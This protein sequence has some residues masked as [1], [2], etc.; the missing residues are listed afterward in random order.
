[1]KKEDVTSFI[2][3]ILMIL[4]ALLLGFTFISNMFKEYNST[5][6]SS[7]LNPYVFAI[8]SIVLAVLVNAIGLEVGH[9]IGGKI[10]GY[11]I[12]SVNILGFCFYKAAGKFKFKF[13]DFDGL[14]GETILA[15]KSEKAN[16]KPYVWFPLLFYFVELIVCIIFNSLGQNSSITLHHNAFVWLGTAAM[17]FITIA[18]MMALYNFVPF[19][20]DSMTDGYRLTLMSKKVNVEA[21]NELMRIE[22]LQR[23]GKEIDKI[24]YF[25]E[26]TEFTA[27]INLMTIYEYLSKKEFEP[28]LALIEKMAE[29]K[30]KLTQATIYRLVAQKLYIKIMTLPIEEAQKYYEEEVDDSIRRFISNDLSMESLRAYILIAGMLD[31]SNAEVT[32]ALSRKEKA[33]KRALKSRA[34]V[35]SKLFDDALELVKKSHPDW[36]YKI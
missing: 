20:L 34:T 7:A 24:K 25:D 16:P 11:T 29:A 30:D 6:G 3:Y 2:V 1:M 17:I 35:E 31:E 14:T 22:N 12:A 27:S 28:A 5:F 33:M 8:I 18:S 23:E 10:G 32:F 36:D 21:Y 26:L 9:I 13:K 4:I 15:P 19:K